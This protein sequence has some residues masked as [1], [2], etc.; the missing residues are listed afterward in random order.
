MSR[1]PFEINT[2][3]N[4][5]LMR[6]DVFVEILSRKP[7]LEG[8]EYQNFGSIIIYR[9]SSFVLISV[10]RGKKKAVLIGRPIY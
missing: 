4:P 5:A 10:I 7:A 1:R 8:K 6:G 2:N 9:R 3:H